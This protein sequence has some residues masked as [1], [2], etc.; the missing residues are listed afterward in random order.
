VN[1]FNTKTIWLNRGYVLNNYQYLY[2]DTSFIVDM[3]VFLPQTFLRN[4][5]RSCIQWNVEHLARYTY[6][7]E[8]IIS[9]PN[10]LPYANL[11]LYC[12]ANNP[13]FVV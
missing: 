12:N 13:F 1:S 11:P 8:Y 9:F 3:G 7:P 6:T 10:Q 2:S 5:P 4:C